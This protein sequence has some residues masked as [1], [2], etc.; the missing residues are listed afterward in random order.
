MDLSYEDCVGE[1]P[2]VRLQRMLPADSGSVVLCP[3]AD[4]FGVLERSS[5]FDF[6]CA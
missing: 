3:L 5:N 4:G 1:T 6:S 2:L